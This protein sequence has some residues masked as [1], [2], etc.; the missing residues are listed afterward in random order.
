MS[1]RAWVVTSLVLLLGSVVVW[2]LIPPLPA[3]PLL[4]DEPLSSLI[5]K[6]G[7]PNGTVPTTA[8][9]WHPASSLAWEKTRGIGVWILEVDW[10]RAAPTATTH[11][12]FV[13]RT[14]RVLGTD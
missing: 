5:T 4:L 12:D 8:V 3:S 1:P 10:D 11:P 2:T 7:P 9:P 6:F 13:S 14:L